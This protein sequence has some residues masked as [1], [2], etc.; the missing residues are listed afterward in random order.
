MEHKLLSDFKLKL[1][2]FEDICHAIQ[3]CHKNNIAH[4][5]IHPINILQDGFGTFK[6]RNF[7]SSIYMNTRLFHPQIIIKF[8]YTRNSIFGRNS[9]NNNNEEKTQMIFIQIQYLWLR[10]IRS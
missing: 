6:I 2:A 8:P 5:S 1:K 10:I 9:T 3:H 7:D 4:L